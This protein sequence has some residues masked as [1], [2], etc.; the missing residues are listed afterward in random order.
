MKVMS[1]HSLEQ[2]ESSTNMASITSYHAAH[3]VFG[4][5]EL[6]CDI[7]GRLPLKDIVIITGICKTWLYSRPC[8]SP[9]Q[10]SATLRPK[11]T[12]SP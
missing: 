5:N 11:W 1:K 10:P 9:Q 6:L 3:A 8:S 2:S 12:A 7:V 4:T